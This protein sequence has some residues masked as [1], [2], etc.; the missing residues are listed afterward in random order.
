MQA[1][2][3]LLSVPLLIA[4]CTYVGSVLGP[5]VRWLY[6]QWR[7]TRAQA[8]LFLLQ[9]TLDGSGASLMAAKG[10]RTPSAGAAA[11]S[12]YPINTSVPLPPL[13]SGDLSTV[14]TALSRPV[15]GDA[16]SRLM[17]PCPRRAYRSLCMGDNNSDVREPVRQ[18]RRLAVI[19]SGHP[20]TM[21]EPD[22]IKSYSSLMAL[23]KRS[24]SVHVFAH[25]VYG[26][27]NS[28]GKYNSMEYSHYKTY[29]RSPVTTASI[30]AVLDQWR[31]PYT[32]QRDGEHPTSASRCKPCGVCTSWQARIQGCWPRVPD[33]SAF[34]GTDKLPGVPTLSQSLRIAAGI[35]MMMRAEE[36]SGDQ[37]DVVLRARPDLCIHTTLGLLATALAHATRCSPMVLTWHD[38]IALL[39]RWAVESFGALWR[40]PDCSGAAPAASPKT[41]RFKSALW[42]LGGVA[43]VGGRLE[44]VGIG[45]VELID[46][47]CYGTEKPKLVAR[48]S[49]GEVEFDTPP[50]TLRVAMRRPYS[51]LAKAPLSQKKGQTLSHK[52]DRWR[53]YS[54]MCRYFS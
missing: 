26:S 36:Q 9:E 39:P 49:N 2:A 52:E 27:T 17:S 32:L 28:D 45:G 4:A 3:A 20:R 21:F 23:A 12:L 31:V 48:S 16:F 11:V 42:P 30:R 8:E 43:H 35:E 5:C 7:N 41:N 51:Y 25:L 40:S 10:A 1:V 13:V 29:Q 15:D 14:T 34:N 38:G 22:V 19:I 44:G 53:E 33:V 54:K 37:F 24:Y 47:L 50:C 6:Q 18:Q 46:F